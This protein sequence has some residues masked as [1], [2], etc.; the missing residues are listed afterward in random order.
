MGNLFMQ[1]F[2]SQNPSVTSGHLR[3]R[4][5]VRTSIAAFLAL[6]LAI[7]HTMILQQHEDTT[8]GVTGC[9]ANHRLK[10][11]FRPKAK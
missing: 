8:Y 1:N 11:Y 6:L 9:R 4:L 7:A 5:S 10:S 2:L 3:N